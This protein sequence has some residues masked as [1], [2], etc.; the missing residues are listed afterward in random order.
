MHIHYRCTFASNGVCFFSFPHSHHETLIIFWVSRWN[1]LLK[2]PTFASN[3]V[4]SPVIF[5][6]PHSH[7]KTFENKTR[8]SINW[9]LHEWIYPYSKL[10]PQNVDIRWIWLTCPQIPLPPIELDPDPRFFLFKISV[11]KPS[12]WKMACES[13]DISIK[14]NCSYLCFFLGA[15]ILSFQA[16]SSNLWFDGQLMERR[17]VDDMIGNAG[18]CLYIIQDPI[19]VSTPS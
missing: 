8:V 16:P 5:S 7:H 12:T 15:R 2:K 13:Q 14:I 10:K 3:R 11:R 17:K 18:N 1:F 19:S 9:T 6:F 4:C